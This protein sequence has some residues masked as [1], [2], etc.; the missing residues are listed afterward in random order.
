MDYIRISP[1]NDDERIHVE[2]AERQQI[3]SGSVF[4]YIYSDSAIVD[5][6]HQV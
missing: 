6:E 3:P 2:A 1:S 5:T 4:D